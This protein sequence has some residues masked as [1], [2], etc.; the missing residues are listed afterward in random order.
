[1]T[2]QDYESLMRDGFFI[3]DGQTKDSA[4][5]INTTAVYEQKIEEQAYRRKLK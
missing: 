4:N 2:A 3:R 1:M 5:V